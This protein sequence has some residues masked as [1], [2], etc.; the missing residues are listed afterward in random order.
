MRTTLRWLLL[1]LVLI[2]ACDD[3]VTGPTIYVAQEPFTI[4]MSVSGASRLQLTGINGSTLVTGVSREDSVFITGVREVGS[5]ES[6][7]D[8]E[9]RLEGLQV[10]F[11]PQGDAIVV[12]T[13]Q[14]ADTEGRNYKVNYEVTLPKSFRT[15]LLT[16]NGDIRVDSMENDVDV[17]I[18]NGTVTLQAIVGSVFAGAANGTILC[19][20]VLPLNGTFDLGVANG[21]IGLTIPTTTS[22]QLVAT[23]GNG[24][25]GIFNLYLEDAIHTSTRVSGR[26]GSGQ[27][28]ITLG[29]GNGTVTAT[30]VVP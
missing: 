16:A 18:V 22:A 24:T 23:V 2:V 25:I 6:L 27:G 8:A 11:G 3:D 30:G 21:E 7:E 4:T 26:L 9:R 15:E 13:Q 17:D 5:Q 29:A 19:E 10:S 20:A 1:V 28:S 12:A 14:P